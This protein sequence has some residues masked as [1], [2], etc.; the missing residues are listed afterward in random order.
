MAVATGARSVLLET[1]RYAEAPE[2]MA[3][4][5]VTQVAAAP[6]M[7]A[8][9]ADQIGIREN[10]ATVRTFASGALALPGEVAERFS[11]IAGKP[12]WEGY[13]MTETSPVVAS[14]LVTGR[15]K[16]GSVGAPLPGVEIRL[17]DSGRI[18]DAAADGD[19]DAP[20]DPLGLPADSDPGE[21]EV[22]GPILFSGYWPDGSDGPGADGWWATG[23]IG[24][25]DAE[26]DLVLLDR[27]RERITV[28]GFTV[29]P[30]EV[31]AA[32]A[33]IAGVA[34]VAVIGDPDPDPQRGEQI[35]AYIVRDAGA[36]LDAAAVIERAG[37]KLARFKV[38]S[39]VEFVA[40][41]PISTTGRVARTR[42]RGIPV[43]EGGSLAVPVEVPVEGAGG[44]VEGDREVGGAAEVGEADGV[45]EGGEGA[46]SDG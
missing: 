22:R 9:W 10:T 6:P 3:A 36:D 33:S 4:Y 38:P 16:V 20:D 29:Y 34:A 1:A 30:R 11:E 23:D 25:Q 32:L 40:A 15:P 27:R 12:V 8:A 43:L 46:T 45:A 2:V 14:T 35:T 18:I 19:E 42:L 5:G 39:R 13:G 24:Y 41:L 37:A 44:A 26:G 7:Y 31:E 28:S 17:V 21:V